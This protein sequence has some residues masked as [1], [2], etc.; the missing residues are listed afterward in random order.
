MDGETRR[1]V[2]VV[3]VAHL[4]CV[5]GCTLGVSCDVYIVEFY[6]VKL[7]SVST[8]RTVAAAAQTLMLFIIKHNA[9]VFVRTPSSV[10]IREPLF[11]SMN[12]GN[13]NEVVTSKPLRAE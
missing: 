3:C 1:S 5:N 6:I 8:P 4:Y 12:G 7:K 13:P 2:C 9:A 11:H 10:N